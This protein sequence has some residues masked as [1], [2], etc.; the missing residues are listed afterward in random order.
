MKG[1]FKVF[2]KKEIED[3]NILLV[4][5]V[6]TTGTTVNECSKVLVRAGARGVFVITLAR[7]YEGKR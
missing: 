6:F 7:T 4:D 5:D 3:K 1:S 2:S